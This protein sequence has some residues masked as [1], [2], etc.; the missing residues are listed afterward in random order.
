MCQV[1]VFVVLRGGEVDF[2]PVEATQAVERHRDVPVED[3]RAAVTGSGSVTAEV[4]DLG[5]ERWPKMLDEVAAVSVQMSVG[6]KRSLTA[7]N[8]DRGS[9][10]VADDLS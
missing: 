3:Q 6:L 5:A 9:E 2:R 8:L 4:E 10:V 1:E 7:Q